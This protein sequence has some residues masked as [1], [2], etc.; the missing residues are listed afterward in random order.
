MLNK[1]TKMK[2]FVSAHRSTA[3]HRCET[4]NMKTTLLITVL[5]TG[6]T[7]SAKIDFD[8][9]VRAVKKERH[10]KST[11]TTRFLTKGYF[12][13][14]G[15]IISPNPALDFFYTYDR[16]QW[17]F[18]VFKAFDVYDHTTTNNFTLAMFRKNINIGKRLTITPQVG[19]ILEQSY[20]FADKGSDLASI[21]ITSYRIS[22]TVTIDQTMIFGNLMVEPEERDM[23]NRFRLLYTK[24]HWDITLLGWHNN[25]WIDHDNSEYFSCGANLLYS[26]IIVS[27]HLM[28]SAGILGVR[29]NYTSTE[30]EYPTRSGIFFT[31]AGYIH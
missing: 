6:Y 5:L 30:S 17:G 15:R 29:M 11:L 18:V 13:F 8:D 20:S 26:R 1:K 10:S 16:N 9:S 4:I 14:T 2:C 21:I 23:A 19:A 7:A 12:S 31:L 25:K 3:T 28:L 27:E 22:K 24:N